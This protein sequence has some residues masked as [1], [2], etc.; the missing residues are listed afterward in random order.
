[1]TP[2]L[3]P[4]QRLVAGIVLVLLI[5]GGFWLAM[6][7]YGQSRYDE[8]VTAERGRWEAAAA[9]LKADASNAAANADANAAGRLQNY[10]AQQE[11]DQAAVNKAEAEGRSPLDALF[12]N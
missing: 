12:G 3:S 2:V 6:H 5:V 1:M 7:S 10:V 8:G 11:A 9:Q 4:L